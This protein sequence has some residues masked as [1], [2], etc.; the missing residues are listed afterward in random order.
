MA[1]RTPRPLDPRGGLLTK[2][3][4]VFTRQLAVDREREQEEEAATIAEEDRALQREVLGEQR[5]F[6]RRRDV[7]AE[8]A[9]LRGQGFEETTEFGLE[10]RPP[11]LSA[12]PRRGALSREPSES[13]V[14]VAGQFALPQREMPGAGQRLTQRT[15][16]RRLEPARD[17][18][19]VHP[20]LLPPPEGADVPDFS[21]L[22]T[23]LQL[24][25]GTFAR[26]LRRAPST[27][28]SAVMAFERAKGAERQQRLSNV[29]SA[30]NAQINALRIRAENQL[31]D[32]E[33]TEPLFQQI[34]ALAQVLLDITISPDMPPSET[35]AEVTAQ[36]NE[37]ENLSENERAVIITQYFE[38]LRQRQVMFQQFNPREGGR[39]PP[40]EPP[41]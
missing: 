36:V 23:K 29:R 20:E 8:A 18:S 2:L 26:A 6:A 3:S 13:R 22:E 40:L 39:R 1:I 11:A 28:I 4:D 25:R 24:P 5:E 15:V 21:D 34:E 10:P 35:L 7:R 32:A 12:T 38:R 19:I 30:I 9:S 27:V 16:R 17:P 31:G 33:T 14:G 37:L 41:R